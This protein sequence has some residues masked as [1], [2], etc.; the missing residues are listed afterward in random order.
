[1]RIRLKGWS[2]IVDSYDRFTDETTVELITPVRLPSTSEVLTGNETSVTLWIVA[3]AKGPAFKD[4]VFGLAL[5]IETNRPAALPLFE[6]KPIY[7]LYDDQRFVL[8]K[9]ARVPDLERRAMAASRSRDAM[10]VGGAVDLAQIEKF[11]SSKSV[12]LKISGMEIR[13]KPEMIASLKAYTE[14]VRKK[15]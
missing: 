14:Y 3:R 4:P 15:L 6:A 1:M 9:T 10:F 7:F 2:Q 5:Q 12:E 13:L 8:E 11:G